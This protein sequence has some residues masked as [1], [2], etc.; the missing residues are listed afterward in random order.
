MTA[1]IKPPNLHHPPNEIAT[2]S[3]RELKMEND[4]LKNEVTSLEEANKA[5]TEFINVNLP[6]I[7]LDDNMF[8]ITEPDTATAKEHPRLHQKFTN[9]SV[10]LS[11][12]KSK[13]EVFE[14]G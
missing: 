6:N 5:L 12:M 8:T 7:D 4:R 3:F 1:R 11:L 13:L 9:L 2:V 14:K 10:K